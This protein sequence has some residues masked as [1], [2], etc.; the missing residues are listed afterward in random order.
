MTES[1]DIQPALP[2][3]S[4]WQE[5]VRFWRQMP[6]KGP[7][8]AML[9]AWLLV[10]QFWGNATFT[11]FGRPIPSLFQ[12]MGLVYY[13]SEDDFHGF[14]VLP[15]VLILLF[16]KRDELLAAPKRVWWPALGLVLVAALLHLGG[17]WVQQPRVSIVACFLGVYAL[18]GLMWGPAWLR[19]TFFPM[20]L[21]AFC[22]PLGA[23]GDTLTLPLRRIVSTIAAFIGGNLLG[24]PVVRDGVQI[25]SPTGGFHFEVA[26][27]CS[28]I[29]SLV[30]LLALTTIYGFL[31]FRSPWRRLAMIGASI[32]LAVIGNVLRLVVIIIVG[33]AFGQEAALT[34]E[35]RF[36][37]VT[38]ALAMVAVFV[39]GWWLREGPREGALDPAPAAQSV[40]LPPSQAA[41]RWIALAVSLALVAGMSAFLHRGKAL[42][43]LGQ[44]GLKLVQ[45]PIYDT[46]T[47]LVSRTSVGLPER[48]LDYA[49]QAMPITTVEVAA[50]PADT[51]FGRR[52]YTRANSP[53]LMLS[54]ILMGTDRSSIHQPQ[55][56]LTAQ[57]WRIEKQELK[58]VRVARPHP[59]D[60]EV[61]RITASKAFKTSDGREALARS[62]YVYWFAADRQLTARHGQRMWWMARDLLLT[63]TLQR[64]AY[65]SCW[66]QCLP[67]QEETAFERLTG[68]LAAAVPEF[69]LSAGPPLSP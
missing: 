8:L 2:S 43:K 6:G 31:S 16:L 7:F 61:M 15:G 27:A 57:G 56:C 45:T 68:F 13:N 28:G 32:P 4:V 5:A 59:Y 10:F 52:L 65:V 38:F 63:G 37:F 66:A 40:P 20:F 47:N 42:H 22:V 58:R 25:Y 24:I 54:V 14:L 35:T 26:A 51:T 1:Q 33:E 11:L 23:V 62:L 69:Q 55:M 44:P 53:P 64:W 39:L 50:L 30:S 60:L 18:T 36:G 29:R 9:A 49:S 3:P 67:G 46:G 34:I 12:W 21:F 41:A 17:Y 48:V 19:A